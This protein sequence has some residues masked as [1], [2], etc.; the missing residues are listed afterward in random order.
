MPDSRVVLPH[1][2]WD[3]PGFVEDNSEK[4]WFFKENSGSG[5]GVA[6]RFCL[7][8]GLNFLIK[9]EEIEYYNRILLRSLTIHYRRETP[10]MHRTL[11]FPVRCSY[12]HGYHHHLN[13]S[14]FLQSTIFI[15]P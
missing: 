11:T 6:E 14:G 9:D 5:I 4:Y 15:V 1:K 10:G 12:S 3:N 13:R 2:G 7:S 8:P